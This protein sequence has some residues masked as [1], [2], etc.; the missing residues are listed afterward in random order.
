MQIDECIMCVPSGKLIL[1]F[2][3]LLLPV[4]I[5]MMSLFRFKD[6]MCAPYATKFTRPAE[7]LASTSA[8]TRVD[9]QRTVHYVTGVSW[10]RLHSAVT[11][12]RN[13]PELDHSSVH[14]AKRHIHIKDT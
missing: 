10:I 7:F 11:W 4:L 13:T 5:L 1:G 8:D 9:M 2:N 14:Y 6:I 3:N 12:T